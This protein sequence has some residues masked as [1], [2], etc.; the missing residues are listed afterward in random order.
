VKLGRIQAIRPGCACVR[1]VH[2]AGRIHLY[3]GQPTDFV[4]AGEGVLTGTEEAKCQG[5][6]TEQGDAC[7]PRS[8]AC[9]KVVRA[10][11]GRAYKTIIIY[12]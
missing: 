7:S 4:D 12:I 10:L 8:S 5:N 1:A 2:E 11:Y 6:L 3:D 9:T